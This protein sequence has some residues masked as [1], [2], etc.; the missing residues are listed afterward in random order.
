MNNTASPTEL[1]LWKARPVD[2]ST[3]ARYF[4][5]TDSYQRDRLSH[6]ISTTRRQ[7]VALVAG[8]FVI[9]ALA[10]AIAAMMPLQKV[11]D[12]IWFVDNSTGAVSMVSNIDSN[13]PKTFEAAVT[14]HFIDLYIHSCQGYVWQEVAQN[15][16]A[17]EL[18]SDAEV[19]DG[20]TRQFSGSNPASP[21][22]IY[23]RKQTVDINVLSMQPRGRTLNASGRETDGFT[24][25]V[26]Y[27]QTVRNNDN[28]A[29]PVS[30]HRYSA[31][32]DFLWRPAKMNKS[33]RPINPLGFL[34]TAYHQQQLGGV[35]Q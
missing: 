18:M 34:V 31:N 16:H 28:P 22:A 13:G 20:V 5:E 8:G 21:P 7:R 26:D 15:F 1:D 4:E 2:E 3:V 17:C 30:V 11:E 25:R 29:I 6:A 14:N 33:D 35:M 12:R 27:Q 24:Y 10:G 19:K 23:G 32:I 9:C